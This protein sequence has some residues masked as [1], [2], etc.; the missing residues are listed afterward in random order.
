MPWDQV[1]AELYHNALAE[2]LADKTKMLI[3]PLNKQVVNTSQIQVPTINKL[4]N[5]A[6]QHVINQ[7]FR[8]QG[9][10]QTRKSFYNVF[11]N[12]DGWCPIRINCLFEHI[13]QLCGPSSTKIVNRQN[14]QVN[15]KTFASKQN[16][17]TKPNPKS[18]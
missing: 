17:Q 13:C 3:P 11:K 15:N 16:H 9:Q 4:N 12:K 18:N 2:G 6:I 8:A 5:R 14:K 7:P 1:V 10:L